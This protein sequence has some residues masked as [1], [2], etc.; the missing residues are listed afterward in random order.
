[1]AT[2]LVVDDRA[3]NRELVRTVL[4][5]S[6]HQVIEAHEG[7][8]ALAMAH[9]QHPDIVL[10]DV[11]MPG[12]DG[13]ELAR[14]LRAAPDTA[15]TPI[16]FYTANY[17]EA[18]TRPFA[19]ACGVA[20]VLLK[21]AD[22]QVLMQTIDD[23]LAEDRSAARPVDTAK[24]DHEYLRAVS[25]KLFDK[26][27]ALTDTETRFRLMADLSP[28][29]IAFGDRHGSANYVN[30]RLTEI[31]GLPA[32]DLLGLGW[33]HCASH[34]DHDEILAVARGHGAGEGQ[35]RYRSQIV[36]PDETLRWVNVHV[37][38][39]RD[40]DGEYTGFIGTV[41]D[42]TA[43]VE[44][45]QE[46]RLAERQND[47]DAKDRATE[48]LDSLST[49]A[50]GVAHD[51]NNILGSMLAFQEFV[52]ESVTE[53]TTAG[54][55]DAETGRAL[56]ADL[57]QI[58]KGGERA[59]GLTQKLLTLGGRSIINPSALDLNRAIRESNELL[60]PTIGA[61]IQIVTHLATDLRPVLAEPAN[62]AQIL[63][64]LT[65]NAAHAMPDGGTLT[66][67]TSN[68]DNTDNPDEANSTPASE[69]VRLTIRDT[70]HGMTPDTLARATDPFFTTKGGG[71]GSGL[72]LSTVHGI[73]SQL[74]GVLRITSTPGRGA[75]VTIHLPTADQ[76][77]DQPIDKPPHSRAPAG[78]SETILVA[79]DED[80]IRDTLTR[81]LTKAG[82]TVL[83]AANGADALKLA[84][85]HTQAIHLLLSDVVMPGM[86][87][88]EL[89][90][91]LL[92]RRPDTKVLFMSGYAG[93]LMNRYGVLEP[94]ITA[95]PKPFTT[96]EILTAVRT[97]IGVRRT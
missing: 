25:A 71:Q 95:L 65:V 37:R 84:E 88:D 34:E 5:Y 9:A 36:M 78:G 43:L 92:E 54:R 67:I 63:L 21:S 19:E 14:E 46:R 94:G 55:L 4:R 87:G 2:V 62:I 90:T 18:E 3:S 17:Q 97:M 56:L 11:L 73:V 61:H 59:T 80:G 81:T 91:H 64:S 60:L 12:M 35:H 49:L 32:D 50:G 1:M 82:Y 68:A 20:R 52:S 27:K 29:G 26:A 28:V 86:L 42:V 31:T 51:F 30:A 38:A 6:G 83:A 75:A 13:Y 72:G 93:D 7:A 45:D 58:R 57:E 79:E 39:I 70:G 15:A 76:A 8:E 24:V 85:Q 16:V 66:I 22:P 33:L 44:A 69:F 10:T 40:D 77:A 23:V 53:L 47:I 41:D 74:G 96:E 89:A 48:R